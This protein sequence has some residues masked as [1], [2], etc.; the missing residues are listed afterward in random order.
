MPEDRQDI[1]WLLDKK[2][3]VCK[4]AKEVQEAEGA[5]EAKEAWEVRG[6]RSYLLKYLYMLVTTHYNDHRLLI[7]NY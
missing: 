2:L 6:L 1:K 3:K 7:T 5:K 4:K